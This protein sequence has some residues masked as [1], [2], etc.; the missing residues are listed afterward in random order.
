ML[1]DSLDAKR[2]VNKEKASFGR[3]F[4]REIVGGYLLAHSELQPLRYEFRLTHWV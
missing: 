2:L 1:C 4:L 3:S